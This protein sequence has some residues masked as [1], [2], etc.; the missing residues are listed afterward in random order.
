MGWCKLYDGD[1][2]GLEVALVAEGL[3]C[4]TVE[5]LG[6]VV[7]L[8]TWA[9]RHAP[10]GGVPSGPRLEGVLGWRG[11][12]GA[13]WRALTAAGVV[14]DDVQGARVAEWDER[15]QLAGEARRKREARARAREARR[16]GA[17]VPTTES[18][19]AD[20]PRTVAGQSEDCPDG[21]LSDLISLSEGERREREADEGPAVAWVATKG[22]P[23]AVTARALD[24]LQ[25]RHPTI[26]VEAE[27]ARAVAWAEDAR[28]D[29]ATRGGRPG[30]KSREKG[31]PPTEGGVSRFIG[32][33]MR[34]AEKDASTGRARP[35]EVTAALA[36]A[37]RG[38]VGIGALELFE[39]RR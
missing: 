17:V 8:W 27:L 33:W 37:T 13:L 4:S 15:Y 35:G 9:T 31:D 18:V 11:E 24:R 39:G 38:A 34:R 3:G 2:D 28:V 14:E 29:W 16:S 32:G 22:Q 19:S 26:D 23:V 6:W 1:P 7:R 10:D 20:S 30:A 36:R 21:V 25:A 12:P 5:A